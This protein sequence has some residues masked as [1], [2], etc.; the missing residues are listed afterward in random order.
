MLAFLTT[1]GTLAY[2]SST[3]PFKSSIACSD[4]L[5]HRKHPDINNIWGT[6]S[7]VVLLQL[8]SRNKQ[9]VVLRVN[10]APLSHSL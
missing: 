6:L 10:I 1:L 4:A 8:G 3:C 5:N 2:P 7:L 9:R